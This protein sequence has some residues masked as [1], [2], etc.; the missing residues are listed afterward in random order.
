MCAAVVAAV[1]LTAAGASA[2]TTIRF[3]ATLTGSEEAPNKVNS[4]AFGTA[5][6]IWNPSTQEGA[7]TVTV[8][9]LP[10]GTTGGHI[11]VGGRDTAG[12][13]I[14]DL[15]PTA[16]LSNDYVFSLTITAGN[17][18]LRPDQGIRSF[19]DAVQALL[20][21]N[22]YVNVHSQVNTG[23]EIRGQLIRQ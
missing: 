6:L 19:D 15:R 3:A 2:Q 16:N 11:H 8:W 4:G 12:P 1:L 7:M 18:T 23:G 5:E 9:N 14:W 21:N 10:S 17:L 20:G 22:T 13:I